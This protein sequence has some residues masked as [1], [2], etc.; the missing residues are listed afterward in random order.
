MHH[1]ESIHNSRFRVFQNTERVSF[2]AFKFQILAKLSPCFNTNH[3]RSR[4]PDF[5][6]KIQLSHFSYFSYPLISCKKIRKILRADSEI[7][8]GR[9]NTRPHGHTNF[10]AVF[11]ELAGSF[12]RTFG[13]FCDELRQFLENLWVAFGELFVMSLGSFWRTFG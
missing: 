11:G 5:F 8:F 3:S 10:W 12:C 6:R 2:V 4:I 7:S 1:W 9:T 13:Q